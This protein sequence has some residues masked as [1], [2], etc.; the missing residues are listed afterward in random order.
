MMLG[1]PVFGIAVFLANIPLTWNQIAFLKVERYSPGY[2]PPVSARNYAHIN[3]MVYEAIVGMAATEI[4][5]F[6]VIIQ[7]E[8]K[9]TGIWCGI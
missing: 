1:W 5:E 3:L 8:H 6:L 2:K 4:P 7:T 9:R